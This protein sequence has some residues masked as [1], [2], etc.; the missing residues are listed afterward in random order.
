MVFILLNLLKEWGS[1]SSLLG[2]HKAGQI[3]SNFYIIIVLENDLINNHMLLECIVIR[4]Q[5]NLFGLHFKNKSDCKLK[6]I[7]VLLRDSSR[8]TAH[9]V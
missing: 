4:C 3:E 5:K 6:N 7:K 8:R 2:C 9:R 1:K